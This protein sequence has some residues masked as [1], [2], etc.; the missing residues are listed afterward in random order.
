MLSPPAWGDYARIV[1]DSDDFEIKGKVLAKSYP[2]NG[3]YYL[4]TKTNLT[5]FANIATKDKINTKEKSCTNIVKNE[6]K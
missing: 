5:Q 2:E 1:Y 4:N 6:K 3:I